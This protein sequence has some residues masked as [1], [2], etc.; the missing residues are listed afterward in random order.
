[1]TLEFNI[2][3]RRGIKCIAPKLLTIIN[4]TLTCKYNDSNSVSSLHMHKHMTYYTKGVAGV[5][6]MITA[7]CSIEM[8]PPVHDVGQ[9]VHTDRVSGKQGWVKNSRWRC[10]YQG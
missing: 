6:I 3:R 1:M 7:G 5:C 8:S 2:E 4:H 10:H 9:S